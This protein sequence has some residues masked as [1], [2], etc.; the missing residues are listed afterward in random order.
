MLGGAAFVLR[1]T[2]FELD[3]LQSEQL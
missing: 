3:C 1:T 2:R